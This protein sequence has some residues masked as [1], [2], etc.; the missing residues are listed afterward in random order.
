[1]EELQEESGLACC[2]CREGY[3]YHPQKVC[4]IFGNEAYLELKVYFERVLET[5]KF[6]RLSCFKTSQCKI[7]VLGYPWCLFAGSRYLHIHQKMHT[8]GIRKQTTKNTGEKTLRI[9]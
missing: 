1:M 5:W 4:C 3:K 8:R 6:K 7:I 2:I 9:W